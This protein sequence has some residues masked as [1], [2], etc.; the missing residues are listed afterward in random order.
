MAAGYATSNPTHLY[1]YDVFVAK[2]AQKHYFPQRALGVHRVVKGAT[3]AFHGDALARSVIH[4]TADDAICTLPYRFQGLIVT[5]QLA[6]EVRQKRSESAADLQADQTGFSQP[7]GAA[8]LEQVATHDEA[9]EMLA[10]A[11][12]LRVEMRNA[13]LFG[14]DSSHQRAPSRGPRLLNHVVAPSPEHGDTNTRQSG[15]RSAITLPAGRQQITCQRG[16]PDRNRNAV[17]A[18]LRI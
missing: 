5:R 17:H 1:G 10:F 18:L 14:D 11:D 6:T 2:L 3:D 9:C 13:W 16:A 15:A 8:H 7:P 4:G 12:F